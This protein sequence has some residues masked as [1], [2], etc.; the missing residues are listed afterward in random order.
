MS[1]TSY[2]AVKGW[3][4]RSASRIERNLK[5]VP[6]AQRLLAIDLANLEA[7]RATQKM[8][9]SPAIKSVLI[10]ESSPFKGEPTVL[11]A[12]QGRNPR[13]WSL[14]VQDGPVIRYKTALLN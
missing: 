7:D 12:T 2:S 9:R 6:Q 8:A 14:L 1:N 5:L 11:A 10:T 4:K 13:T 3:W